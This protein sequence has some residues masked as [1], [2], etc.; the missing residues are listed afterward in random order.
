[1]K[2]NV[3]RLTLCAMLYALCASAEAQQSGKIPRVGILFI[4]GRDQ[5]HLQSFKEGLHERG[6]EEGKNI[7]LEYKY[8]EGKQERLDELAAE[9]VRDKVDIIVTTASVSAL[10]ARKVTQIIPIIMT[11]G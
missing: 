10:A 4:G 6:Y 5:P 11:S 7:K 3:M 9:F 2:K 8:A 1:M